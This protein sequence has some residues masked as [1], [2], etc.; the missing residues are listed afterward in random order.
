MNTFTTDRYRG[1]RVTVMGLGKFG[2]GVG[3]ARFL[4]EQGAL[5]TVT[6]SK[7]V[8]SL[9]VSLDG[10]KGIDVIRHLGGHD[11]VDFTQADLVV[12]SP[13]VP[14][15][16]PF[17]EA[18]RNA[19]VELMTEIGLFVR[20]CPA[21]ICGITGSNGK[22]TTVSMTGA[23]LD[24][25][26][27][28]HWV[29]GNI[30][31]SL[32][33]SLAEMT[34]DDSV[35]LELS[36]FQLEWLDEMGWSPEIAA[37]LNISPNHLDRHGTF[38]RYRDAKGVIFDHQKQTDTAILVADPPGSAVYRDRVRGNLLW[39]GTSLNGDG[40]TLDDGWIS[41]RKEGKTTRIIEAGKLQTPGA[42]NVL[43][44]L[45]AT[46][47]ALS[48]G[49][50]ISAI[51]RGLASF[52]GV[53]HRIQFVGKR[54]GVR[55]YNDSK[56]TT[57]ESTVVAVRAFSGCVIPILGGYDKGVTFDKMA[58]EIAGKV[59]WAALI[60]VTAGK[61]R[62]SLDKAGI[63]ST[64]YPTLE[65]AFAA[66]VAKARA[67]DTVLLSPG[68]ASYDMFSDYEQRGERFTGLVKAYV[69]QSS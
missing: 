29:G 16:S 46:A 24:A 31:G 12:A 51:A 65:E 44:A 62:S 28:R 32:L 5:V 59:P 38:E 45:A 22:T 3:A 57:P 11:I 20:H 15:E 56:A 52:R 68:C 40:V 2:G 13:A 35:V 23:I 64:T 67:G 39:A 54:D 27:I 69:E 33:A 50:D 10:L 4:A 34:P 21:H 60:G 41:V 58:E 55:F 8:E 25:A 61:I 6:D 53:Q 36:S 37:I 66:C 1:K 14:R 7:P 47:C 30:G 26:H 19:G 18:A 42:H 49:A 9:T 43:N 63:D 17:L 48:L